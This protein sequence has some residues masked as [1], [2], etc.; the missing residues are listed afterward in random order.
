M[1]PLRLRLVLAAAGLLLAH[2][3][4]AETSKLDARAR[5]ALAQLQSGAAPRT[6]VQRSA[7]VNELGEIDCFIV[8]NVTRAQLEAAGARIRT[9][10]GDV[11]T[12]YV[13]VEAMGA[14]EALA[15]VRAISGAAPVEEQN[16]LGVASTNANNLR[17]AGPAF[18]GLNGQNV[19]VGDVDSGIDFDHGDFKDAGGLTRLVNIWDQTVAGAPPFGFAYGTEWNAA[20]INGALC[21]ETDVS[22]HGTHVMGTAGGD[23][24]STGGVI[25][26]FTYAGMAPRAD[27]IMVKTNF[28]TTGVADGVNYIFQR[29]TALGKNAV[30]NLSLGTQFGP[31]DGTSPFEASLTAITGPGRLVV[32]SE[33]NDRGVA[34]HA[35]TFATALGANVTMT[36]TGSGAARTVAI[37]GYYEASEN[38]NVTITTPNATVIGPITVG[39]MN[40]AFPGPATG[41]G[42]VYVENG[43]ALTATGDKQVYIEINVP[44][45]IAG[46][47]MNG[48]WTFKFTAVA[49]GAANGEVDLWRFFPS[50]G[51]PVA[52]FAIGNQATEELTS[53]PACS[54]GV[55]SVAA[56]NTRKTW[57]ACDGFSYSFTGG[58]NVGQLAPF[59]SP[60]P[61]RDSRKKPDITAPGTAIVSTA[62]TDVANVCGPLFVADNLNHKVNQGTS[63]AAPH[64]TG[65]VALLMQKYGAITPAFAKSFFTTRAVIDANTGAPW[66]K[67]W[68][69]G[70]LFL[71]DMV[72]PSVQVIYPNGGE[73]F[74]YG[75]AVNLQWSATD[76]VG[77]TNVDL[78]LSRTGAGGPYVLLAGAVP[79]TGS[80]AWTADPP[81]SNNVFLRVVATDGAGNTGQDQ[82]DAAWAI[83]D[84]ATATL[85]SEFSAQSTD[86]AVE[87]RWR[88][89]E[90]AAFSDVVVQRASRADGPWAAQ[91]VELRDEQGTSIAVD[92]SVQ[93]GETWFYRLSAKWGDRTMTFGPL[94]ATAGEAIAEF[95]LSRP[96]PN[97][98]AGAPTRVEFTLPRMANVRVTVLDPM[99]REVA[100]LVEGAYLPGRHQATW[101]GE[102][103]GRRAPAGLYFV[104]YQTPERNVTRRV[105][106]TR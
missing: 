93:A 6:L 54:D 37:D 90:P 86:R 27:L 104:R 92:R 1:T 26:A 28:L 50:S 20:Q 31:H 15:G 98:S 78:Y 17:G 47:N 16:D 2:G 41:N 53:E 12:A 11:F 99:G 74:F 13:P 30:V 88:F 63:M 70:K 40:A 8:G 96:A 33:G 76:N 89:G 87:L 81:S 67:D 29:A 19:L 95:G 65:A 18:T 79:N 10:M 25:P 34:R 91:D 68:G 42:Q 84:G 3:A 73:T 102:I 82:S 24:S 101:S 9:Q 38:L 21:T 46:Q 55:I 80:Y 100:T 69:N 48:T 60:G 77:V 57:A 23:G 45:P 36:V 49:L 85:L 14:I 103:A 5:V 39:N 22:T 43:V 7:A 97:P 51:N 105:V 56:W 106:I 94:Q 35:E 4:I 66:N 58:S 72:D 83:I 71:G 64:V 52:N 75:Q 61:T 59:S 44:N 62:S 32:V